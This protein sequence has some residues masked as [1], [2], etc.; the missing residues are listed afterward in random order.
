MNLTAKQLIPAIKDAFLNQDKYEMHR[1]IADLSGGNEFFADYM[2]SVIMERKDPEPPIFYTTTGAYDL[3]SCVGLLQSVV[4][5]GDKVLLNIP[6]QEYVA[7]RTSAIL[8]LVLQTLNFNSLKDKNILYI[9]T[10]RLAKKSIQML[11]EVYPEVETIDFNNK[12]GKA[13]EFLEICEKLNVKAN[14]VNLEDI[15][16]YD[17]IFSYT[18]SFATNVL[19][20]KH[21]KQLKK[22]A[23]IGS[24]ISSGGEIDDSFYLNKNANII[25]DWA[26]TPDLA[27]ELQSL[28]SSGKLNEKRFVY[29]K[30]LLEENK[31]VNPDADYTIY[32]SSGTPMQ[33]LAVLKILLNG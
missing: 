10:G 17:Y 27:L 21:L 32:R 20:D 16:K 2:S 25:L 14:F 29:L 15:S 24:F 26:K 31:E 6:F 5:Q 12:S 30:E 4:F 19:L 22:G 3:I 28:I 8:P 7:Q 11:K 33:N 13:G 18:N 9:G 23:F 1:D